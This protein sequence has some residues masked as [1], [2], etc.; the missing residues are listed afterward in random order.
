M[1]QTE[2]AIFKE[3]LTGSLKN[4]IRNLVNFHVSSHKSKNVHFD[5]FVLSKTY[6]VSHEKEQKIYVS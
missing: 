6:K 2:D 3:K 4:D 1:T 5:G